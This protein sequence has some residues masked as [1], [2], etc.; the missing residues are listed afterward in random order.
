MRRLSWTNIE[1]PIAHW[2]ELMVF[3]SIH[4]LAPQYM[5]DIFTNISQITSHNHRNIATD[6]SKSKFKL[7]L[8]PVAHWAAPI[9]ISVAL[10]QASAN[11]VKATTGGWPTGSSACLTFPLHSHMSSAR[12]EGSKY[13]FKSLWYDSA[14][15]QPHDLPVVRQTLYH[16]TITPVPDTEL[17][18]P[19]KRSFNG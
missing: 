7:L 11:A 17:W 12:R 9:S 3:K 13:H 18:L 2:S 19:Q 8:A 10:G 16:W 1:E 6:P 5:S 15:V 4:G 14:G